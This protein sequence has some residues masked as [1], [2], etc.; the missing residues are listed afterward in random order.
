MGS[1]MVNVNWGLTNEM[2]ISYGVPC[3]EDDEGAVMG[4]NSSGR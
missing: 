2:L 4:V 1:V 3:L